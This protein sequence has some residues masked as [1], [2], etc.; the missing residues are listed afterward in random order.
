[1]SVQGKEIEIMPRLQ[2]LICKINKPD[3]DDVSLVDA[4]VRKLHVQ[5]F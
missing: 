5:S 1:M 3:A 2:K 4:P